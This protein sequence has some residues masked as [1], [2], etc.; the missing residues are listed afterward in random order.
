[1]SSKTIHRLAL[2]VGR[3]SWEQEDQEAEGRKTWRP[4]AAEVTPHRLYVAT[5]GVTVRLEEGFKEAKVVT[6][7][8]ETS[9]GRPFRRHRVRFEP[10]EPFS[11]YAWSLA[12]RCGLAKE[13]ETVE[14]AIG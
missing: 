12:C 2:R 8:G 10:A 6:C 4:C 14:A 3:T 11:A 7:Y 1:M 5:D 13:G 9:P